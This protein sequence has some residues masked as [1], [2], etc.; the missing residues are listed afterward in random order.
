M[1]ETRCIKRVA[2]SDA[3]LIVSG[4]TG[5]ETA[6]HC[7]RKASVKVMPLFRSIAR[8]FLIIFLKASFFGH[9]KGAFTGAETKKGLFEWAHN[10]T[11]FLDEIGDLNY[12]LQGKLLRALQERSIRRVGGSTEIPVNVRLISA[13]NRDLEQMILAKSF[14]EDLYYRLNVIKIAMPVIAGTTRGYSY[15]A[16]HF[17]ERFNHHEKNRRISHISEEAMTWLGQL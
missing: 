16:A 6:V 2:Q 15:L 5:T 1:A 7:M 12:S 8:R 3:N 13:T 4:E 17:M 10:G 9:E 14:R 11:L